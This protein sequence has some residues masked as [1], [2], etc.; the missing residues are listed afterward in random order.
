MVYSCAIMVPLDFSLLCWHDNV[1]CKSLCEH[2]R[3]SLVC[4]AFIF[5]Q[6]FFPL[7]TKIRSNSSTGGM[8][9]FSDTR[10]MGL[11]WRHMPV[12][13]IT[14]HRLASGHS[15]METHANG[16]SAN[17]LATRNYWNSPSTTGSFFFSWSVP[18]LWELDKAFANSWN[19]LKLIWTT[20]NSTCD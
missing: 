3:A 1:Y 6:R 13:V 10:L 7:Q 12:R 18:F 19:S 15:W 14:S 9:L 8:L 5:P 17:S 20:S 16:Q 4:L 11:W 2:K